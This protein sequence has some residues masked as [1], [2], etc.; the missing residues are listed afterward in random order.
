MVPCFGTL[1]ILQSRSLQN[2]VQNKALVPDKISK[3]VLIMNVILLV[4]SA[5]RIILF[6]DEPVRKGARN[7]EQCPSSDCPQG[8]D[9]TVPETIQ[10]TDPQ[11]RPLPLKQRPCPHEAMVSS[12]QSLFIPYKT[13]GKSGLSSVLTTSQNRRC[14][15]VA[16]EGNA[17]FGPPGSSANTSFF[18]HIY[19]GFSGR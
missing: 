8:S 18:N 17:S 2:H 16:V 19:K 6:Q 11:P 7:Q 10:A 1:M 4:R 12:G 13:Q 3:G 5:S 9:I 15:S 14:C